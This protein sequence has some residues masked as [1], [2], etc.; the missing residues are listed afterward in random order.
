VSE[1]IL[2]GKYASAKIYTDNVESA[3]IGQ[4]MSL[5]NQPFVEGSKIR[6]MP[7]THAGAGC[8]IGT[9]MTITDKVVPNLVGVDIG[10]GMLSIKL[11]EKR[12]DL[13]AFDAVVR[14]YVPSGGN[15]HEE[16]KGNR[17]SLIAE[18]LRC[19]GKKA[20][21]IRPDL[22][23]KSVG[24]LGGGNH[25]IE[26]DRDK[27]G[28]I[29]LV[30]HTGSRHLGIEVCNFYQNAGYQAL[31]DK[32]NGGTKQEKRNAFIAQLK[33]DGR[34]AE[35]DRA[36]K[37]W[38]KNYQEKNP[39]V[40]YDLAYVEG[41]LFEDYIHDMDMVQK[42]AACNRAEIARVIL[43]HA[44]LHEVERFETIH[45]YIDVENMILRKGSVSA[46]EGERLLIPINMRD[47]SLICVGKGNPDWNYSAPH[48]A[49]RLMSRSAAKES[50]SM[51]DFKAAMEGI[52]TTCVNQGTI[53]E[54]PM[55]YKPIDEIVRNIAE[56]VD[57][58]DIIK[59]IYNFKA[60]ED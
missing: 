15:V 1:I 50:I 44:K 45:N 42:H 28:N 25:F 40:P 34:H 60:S 53:D 49:G 33:A 12:I 10:C 5:L 2:N 22:A 30:I 48:G 29:W 18:N 43:K 23:Y 4:M 16:E 9:T 38:D 8:V 35:I 36:C 39:S 11:K 59:P 57:I 52:Y 17:T 31:K 21:R 55:A 27:D 6:I 46:R 54:S 13:P 14:K 26:L 37:T 51:G 7:D 3:A 56:T 47:G 24:T 41:Q 58:I 32:A 19:F 20:A